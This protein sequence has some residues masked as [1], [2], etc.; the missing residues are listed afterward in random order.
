MGGHRPTCFDAATPDIE[1]ESWRS[2]HLS[3]LLSQMFAIPDFFSGANSFESSRHTSGRSSTVWRG[4][5]FGS[6]V[7]L[8]LL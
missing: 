6:S 7:S 4:C 8:P 5:L 1:Y 2:F 3:P